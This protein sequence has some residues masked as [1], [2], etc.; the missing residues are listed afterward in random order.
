MDN[1]PILRTADAQDPQIR[2]RLLNL[3]NAALAVDGQS[4]FNDQALA[5][6]TAGRRSLLVVEDAPGVSPSTD[7]G[8]LGA[9]ILGQGELEFTI[10]PSHRRRGLGAKLLEQALAE[11]GAAENS[12]VE[13]S[14]DEN[15][16]DENSADENTGALL[17]WSHGDHPGARVLAART[18]FSPVRTLLQLRRGESAEQLDQTVPDPSITTFRVGT[19]ESAW[20]K[21]NSLAFA[22]HPEQ[23]RLTLADLENRM[24]EPWFSAEN[25]LVM[26]NADGDLVGFNWLKVE[27]EN[28]QTGEIYAI[29]VHPGS[30]GK[31]IGRRLMNAGLARLESIGATST[32]LYVEADNV[33]AVALYRSLG[34]TD[35]TVDVQYLRTGV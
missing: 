8:L 1:S 31:G 18:R 3:R 27:P 20:L 24:A 9:A 26:H 11:H 33:P 28:P 29:G 23:G 7:A 35:H 13:N 15:S 30:A 22:H 2:A 4:A 10:T 25:F 12:A 6:L 19:D 32:T 5:D 34:F 17:A 16:A 14:A 21:L